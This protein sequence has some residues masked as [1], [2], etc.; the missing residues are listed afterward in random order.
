MSSLPFISGFNSTILRHSGILGAADDAELNNFH[1]K[2]LS[3]IAVKKNKIDRV[4]HL[5]DMV[6]QTVV[7]TVPRI[8]CTTDQAT[9][10]GMKKT[11]IRFKFTS[12]SI[13]EEVSMITIQT[14]IKLCMKLG[15]E[16]M[17]HFY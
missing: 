17:T 10:H 9:F 13:Q 14:D 4:I 11:I 2:I 8:P 15:A 3:N 6:M 16:C 5:Q 1:K 7:D 12:E